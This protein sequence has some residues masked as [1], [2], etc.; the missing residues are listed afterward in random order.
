MHDHLGK[1]VSAISSCRAGDVVPELAEALGLKEALNW[2]KRNRW[3]KAQVETDSLLV[4]Q[5]IRGQLYQESYF[6]GVIL[7]CLSIWETL[8]NVSIVFVK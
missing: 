3:I 1:F 8:P 2:I 5:A 6:G 7:E 4:I